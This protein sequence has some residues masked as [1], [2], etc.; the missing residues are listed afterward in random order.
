MGVPS[1]FSVN[2]QETLLKAIP[3]LSHYILL[4]CQHLT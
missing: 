2:L 3:A 4:Q 1:D